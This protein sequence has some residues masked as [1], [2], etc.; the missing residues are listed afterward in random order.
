MRIPWHCSGRAVG[1]KG[2][3]RAGFGGQQ[4]GLLGALSP[5]PC[6][7]LK[8]A[9]L[10]WVRTTVTTT[11]TVKRSAQG[12]TWRR[13]LERG[14]RRCAIHFRCLS[15]TTPFSFKN[16]EYQVS[17]RWLDNGLPVYAQACSSS[18]VMYHL[19]RRLPAWLVVLSSCKGA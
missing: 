14:K 12:N 13:L 8:P 7:L 2:K 1:I 6:L 17:R 3:T 15:S 5:D 9:L 4:Q 16:A 18:G 10:L 19:S 11:D